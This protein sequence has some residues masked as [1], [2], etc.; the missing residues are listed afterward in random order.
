MM[1]S[2]SC[3]NDHQYWYQP[4]IN[5][6]SIELFLSVIIVITFANSLLSDLETAKRRKFNRKSFE[7]ILSFETSAIRSISVL[8][9]LT[10]VIVIPMI[11]IKFSFADARNATNKSFKYSKLADDESKFV[12]WLLYL[13]IAG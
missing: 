5:T 4:F 10:S 8:S 1:H 3:G 11:L 13:L 2:N 12:S 7:K 9:I 6:H